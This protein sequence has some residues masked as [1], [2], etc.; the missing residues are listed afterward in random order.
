M[1]KQSPRNARLSRWTALIFFL[2]V[3]FQI[4]HAQNPVLKV[5]E[6]W[7][8]TSGSQNMFQRSVTRSVPGTSNVVIAGATINSNGDYDI[9]VQKI[10]GSGS[11][12]WSA[13][14]NGV[15]NGDDVATDIRVASNG[16]I[17]VCGAYYKDA[18]DSSNAIVIKYDA[19]GNQRWTSVYNGSGSRNDGYSSLLVSGAN[20]YAVGTCWSTANQYDM[21]TT[22]LDTAGTS[23]F[24]T[25]ADN[26]GLA[27][28]AVSLSARS[29][30]LFVVGGVQ[31]T[32]TSYKIATWKINPLTGAIITTTLSSSAPFG[33]D[34]VADVKEDASGNVYVAGSVYDVATGFDYKVFKY[35]AS[36]ALLWSATWDGAASL[37]DGITGLALDQYGK[38]IVTGYTTTAQGKDFATVKYSSA[39][40]LQWASIFDGG[41]NDSATCIVVN[42]TDTNKIYVSGYSFNGSTNDYWTMRYD[43]GGTEKWSI[44]FD[45]PSDGLDIATAIAL[46]TLKDVIVSGQNRINDS[47]FIYTTVKY[48]EKFVTTP[49]SSDSAGAAFCFRANRGQVFNTG[50]S[51]QSDIK[52]YNLNNG[53]AEQLYFSDTSLSYVW[54]KLDTASTS[55]S[56]TLVRVDMKHLYSKPTKKIYATS[57]RREYSNYLQT[58][59]APDYIA[60]VKHYNELVYSDV[61][62]NTDVIYSSNYSGLKYY[63][64][65][66]PGGSPSIIN[67]QYSGAQSVSV[68]GSGELIVSTQIGN[69]VYAQPNVW[70]IDGSGSVVTLPWQPTWSVTDSTASFSSIGTFNSAYILV[71]EITKGYT[72]VPTSPNPNDN[73]EWATYYAAASNGCAIH[74]IKTDKHGNT[75]SIGG[76]GTAFFPTHFGLQ[77]FPGGGVDL[78]FFKF[79]STANWVWVTYLGGSPGEFYPSL[80]LDTAGNVFFCSRVDGQGSPLQNLAGAYYDNTFN[81]GFVDWYLGKIKSDGTAQTWG[82]YF[83]GSAVDVPKDIRVLDDNNKIYVVG[84]T[85]STNFPIVNKPGA[86]NH[87]TGNI[88]IVEFNG[89]LDT[90]WS[91][92][93]GGTSSSNCATAVDG[94]ATHVLVVGYK[95]DNSAFPIVNPGGGAYCDSIAD[96]DG[97]LIE[98][99]QNDTIVWSTGFGGNQVDK[100]YDVLRVATPAS[101]YAQPTSPQSPGI[102]DIYIVGTARSE[103]NFPLLWSSGEYIDSLVTQGYGD[104]G[105]IARFNQQGVLQWSSLYGDSA[106]E[107][108]W[109]VCEDINHNIYTLGQSYSTNLH[110]QTNNNAYYQAKLGPENDFIIGVNSSNQVFW[111]T[112]FGGADGESSGNVDGDGMGEIAAFRDEKVYI[113]GSTFSLPNT[114]P[115]DYPV[116]GFID[117]L[118]SNQFAA[119][120]FIAR[121]GLTS[122][123]T[124]IFEEQNQISTGNILVFPNPSS[125]N[126]TVQTTGL[127]GEN[128]EISVYGLL[129]QCVL[130]RKRDNVFGTLQENIDLS[131]TSTGVYFVT[132]KVGSA[133]YS[134]KI[135][136]Q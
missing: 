43:G 23:L 134:Q 102:G 64:V 36:L 53:S 72:P 80:D 51:L 52:F 122:L 47:T 76:A 16:E 133:I 94:D 21:L 88:A 65:I 105:F 131:A 34:L 106:S 85:A 10:S 107:I 135:I 129:G 25:T 7:N 101:R 132:V 1:K 27:D 119:C 19:S 97:F 44:G 8:T 120:G 112:F 57:E 124:G 104:D 103:V 28:G 75:L 114:F 108:I 37:D 48:V 70:Q 90:T 29:G 74:G 11:V 13:Q 82:T 55:P 125:G 22:R 14:Y 115:W 69:L 26:A 41:G 110:L 60:R 113:V 6:E 127:K 111:A 62:T 84:S 116:G 136:K 49:T 98:F 46:D 87:S 39:G 45:S 33:I 81:G 2:C 61:Y 109:S 128:I 99:N 86:Y 38:V 56:D 50:D 126:F 17:Y 35:D 73:L 130:S 89:A 67:E 42:Q 3:F 77:S 18:T 24:T 93:I 118:K 15:G 71:I 20:V 78:A 54:D 63:Y 58:R 31:S 12:L 32:S 121:F 95:V 5:F 79:D 117:T 68:G 59:V 40:V 96:L 66:K 100:I 91:V 123:A 83:G 92:L 30:S 9:F 4:A